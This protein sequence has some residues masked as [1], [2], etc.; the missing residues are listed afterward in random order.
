MAF[1]QAEFNPVHTLIPRELADQARVIVKFKRNSTLLQKHKLSAT[2]NASYTL[3]TVT[4]RANSLGAR[5]GMNLR[6]G[7][8]I[9][10][11]AQVINATGIS[12]AVL[13]KILATEADVEYA[14]VDQL[15]THFMEPNDPLY[16]QGSAISGNTGG[17]AVGQWYLHAPTGEAVASINAPGAWDKTSGTPNIVVAVLDT[18]VRPE[19]PD[20]ANRLLPGYDMVSNSL[21]ANDGSGR[22]ADASDPGDWVTASESSNTSSQFYQCVAGNSS[23]HGTKTAGIIGAVTN[24]GVGMAGLASGVKLLP[25]RVLGKCGG[26]D[27]DII[28]GMQWAAGLSVPGV[29]ANPN[30]A[31]I[32]NMSLG[33]SGTCSQ[34]YIDTINTITGQQNPVVIVVAAGNDGQS[35]GSPANCPGVI[36]VSGLRHMGTKVGFSN[37]GS[38]ISIS[39]PG[40]NCV[41][42]TSSLPCLYP[43]LT[44][45]NTGTTTP[46]ASS[47]TD[48]FNTSLGTSFSAPLVTGTVALML[49]A[50]SSLT[51]ADIKTALQTSARA[52]P[53]RGIPDDPQTGPIQDCHAPGSS[54]QLQCYCTTLTCGA[55]MLDV[56]SALAAALGLQPR[57]SVMPSTLHPGETATLGSSGSLVGNGRNIISYQWSIVDGGGLLTTF[58]GDT[59]SA[60]ATLTPDATGR[61]SVRLTV[62]DDNGM[63]AS[64]ETVLSV[65]PSLVV[66]GTPTI[67]TATSGNGSAIISFS[68][69]S[70]TGDSTIL[71]YTVISNP[72][73]LTAMG[74]SSPIT[75]TGLT[76]GIAYTFTVNAFN[77]AGAS[78]SSDVS[79]S[80][81]PAAPASTFTVSTSAG[82]NGSMSPA[83]QSVTSGN[84]TTFTVSPN[85]GYNVSVS[86]CGGSLNGTTYTT[87]VITA[88]CTVTATFNQNVIQTTL[89]EGW[90]LLGNSVNAPLV[91]STAFVN[92]SNVSTVWKWEPTGN[93][94]GISYPAWAFYTPALADG[95]AAYATSKGYDFLTTINGG[96]GFWVN[97]KVAFTA[98]LPSGTAILS[99]AFQDGSATGETN[100]L[101]SGWS[102]IATGDNPTPK[103]FANS[104]AATAPTPGTAA[105]SLSTLWAWDSASMSWYFY[106]P[107]LDNTGT[108]A[109]YIIGKSY[110]DFT[111]KS[112]T[113]D[114]TTGF[115]VNHP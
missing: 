8:A 76:N 106:A 64:A 12:S 93:A 92:A 102:L 85:S 54:T 94:L 58:N 21:S 46:A 83:S 32:I 89:A 67:G 60:L 48:S 109:S 86:G 43:I 35:V 110:E 34:S 99:S 97:A 41:N 15:R 96:E 23:W 31:R 6:A 36:A 42:T 103:L 25:V 88:D 51:L 66:P 10:E 24:N 74:T 38:E 65:V 77:S 90:N 75:I 39:A 45:T 52:F 44:A 4:A 62:T 27:S 33:S 57:I 80:V 9:S 3:D 30:P 114:T 100:P 78:A 14:V 28:A 98:L 69:P 13:A 105:A 55:G 19:H 50:Q 73:G 91:V 84:M 115:W 104:I 113:L 71:G 22:D 29:P 7:R 20:L 26:Y 79:N 68:A 72:G 17:P 108:L 49:S 81:T 111:A 47:Y 18:G 56:A 95:G 5:L 61:L 37:L 53:F 2:A 112:K 82:A 63:T 59:T 16:T 107:I 40:G 87:G 1:A 11:H 101:P 70:N